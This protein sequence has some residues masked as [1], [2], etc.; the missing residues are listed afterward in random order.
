MLFHLLQV[1][2][3]GGIQQDR[4][5]QKHLGRQEPAS[6]CLR[7]DG[8]PQ[9]VRTIIRKRNMILETGP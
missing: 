9:V 3:R 5:N 2:D 4:P 8:R 1:G 6:I 7:R